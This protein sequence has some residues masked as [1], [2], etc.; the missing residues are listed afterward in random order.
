MSLQI[1]HD[2]LVVAE[3]ASGKTLEV[4]AIAAYLPGAFL[5]MLAT[6]RVDPI[7]VRAEN[8]Y[9]PDNAVRQRVL[10]AANLTTSFA[11]FPFSLLPIRG[12]LF[13]WGRLSDRIAVI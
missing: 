7:P 13:Y 9:L 8:P 2:S 10:G 12:R 5:A 11:V 6:S 3:L 1:G 4:L